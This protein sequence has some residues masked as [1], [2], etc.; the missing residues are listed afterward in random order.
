MINLHKVKVPL[1]KT[2]SNPWLDFANW[3]EKLLVISDNKI[4]Q[5]EGLAGL[6]RTCYKGCSHCCKLYIE[7][8]EIEARIISAWIVNNKKHLTDKLKD[9]LDNFDKALLSPPHS[10]SAFKQFEKEYPKHNY[11]CPFLDG[12]ECSIYPVR[13]ILCS[14]YL[15]YNN[16]DICAITGREEACVTLNGVAIWI[17]QN[18]HLFAQYNQHKL[19]LF[20]LENMNRI[21]YFMPLRIYELFK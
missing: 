18:I 14:T 6:T 9:W 2:K 20:N 4:N 1:V 7:V 12:S 19:K 21:F 8:T 15:S 5:W 13:P 10:D 16:P 3:Y 11:Y 17:F